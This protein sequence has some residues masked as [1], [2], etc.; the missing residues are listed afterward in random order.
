M[1][2]ELGGTVTI[3]CKQN[4]F[5][6]ELEF[7]LK[8]APAAAPGVLVGQSEASGIPHPA[9]FVPQ[10]WFPEQV[11]MREQLLASPGTAGAQSGGR[12]Q[13]TQQS[14]DRPKW[15]SWAWRQLCILEHGLR[16][17]VLS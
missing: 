17:W 15:G 11:H 9:L 2:M 3:K 10:K 13:A 8:V 16:F 12:P 14:W 4:K 1:T 6:A 7:K 5:Q